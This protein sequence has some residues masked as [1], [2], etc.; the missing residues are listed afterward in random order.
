MTDHRENDIYFMPTDPELSVSVK[1]QGETYTG[2]YIVDE[3]NVRAVVNL[4]GSSHSPHR[5]LEGRDP[6]TVAE[7]LVYDVVR[8]HVPAANKPTSA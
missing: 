4:N 7:E 3:G 8:M 1:Y 6:Q 2:I 5:A